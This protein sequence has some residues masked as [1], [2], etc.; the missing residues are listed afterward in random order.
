MYIHV[1]VQVEKGSSKV[2]DLEYV[3]LDQSVQIVVN[4][5]SGLI[6]EA[7]NESLWELDN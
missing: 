7:Q 2:I 4:L 1:N 5:C 6:C 3:D